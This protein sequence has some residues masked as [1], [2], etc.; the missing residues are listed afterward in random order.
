MSPSKSIGKALYTLPYAL[1]SLT[2]YPL[3]NVLLHIAFYSDL[4]Y[5]HGERRVLITPQTV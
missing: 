2:V 3:L 5:F 1:S 4:F